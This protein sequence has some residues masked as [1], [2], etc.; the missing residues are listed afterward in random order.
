MG[1]TFYYFLFHLASDTRDKP[2]PKL[3]NQLDKYHDE[4][5]LSYSGIRRNSHYS[6]IS[7][8]IFTLQD[9]RHPTGN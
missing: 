8:T 2:I 3:S 9:L 5:K 4:I 6:H 1:F 7:V